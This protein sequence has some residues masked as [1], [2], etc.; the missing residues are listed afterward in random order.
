M[1]IVSIQIVNITAGE[2]G[3]TVLHMIDGS[4]SVVGPDWVEKH[5]P[6]IGGFLIDDQSKHG[7]QWFSATGLETMPAV[8]AEVMRI[9]AGPG[10]VVLFKLPPGTSMHSGDMLKR[11]INQLAPDLPVLVVSGDMEVMIVG[12]APAE[13][14]AR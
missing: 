3:A 5:R 12:A 6:A 1:A 10:E 11:C 8:L 13:A 4:I 7:Q 2:G 9:S 14:S